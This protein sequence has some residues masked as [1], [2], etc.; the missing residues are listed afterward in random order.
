[1]DKQSFNQ[2][3]S[4]P[5]LYDKCLISCY[6]KENLQE[7]TSRVSNAVTNYW[8]AV[9]NVIPNLVVNVD[10]KI[11]VTCITHANRMLNNLVLTSVDD[12]TLASNCVR[13]DFGRDKNMNCF[14]F[15]FED[16]MPAAGFCLECIKHFL[17][18]TPHTF[19][20]HRVKINYGDED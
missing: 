14:R 17:A 16:D 10:K 7:L 13:S 9:V 18:R 1:M 6:F 15:Y 8:V 20:L 19:L 12:Q 2:I 3:F 4:C 11:F 5:C